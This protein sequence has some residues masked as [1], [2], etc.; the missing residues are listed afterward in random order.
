MTGALVLSGLAKRHP[1]AVAPLFEDLS[2]SV[3]PG[4]VLVETD[5]EG[6]VVTTFTVDQ[7]EGGR[8]ARVST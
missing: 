6:A 2:L 7:A 4:R 8:R 1:G 5:V 3:E